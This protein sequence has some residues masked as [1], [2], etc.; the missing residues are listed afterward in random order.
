LWIERLTEHCDVAGIVVIGNENFE[1][2]FCGRTKLAL[3]CAIGVKNFHRVA[4]WEMEDAIVEGTIV[5]ILNFDPE[6]AVYTLL[7]SWS[8]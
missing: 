5:C 3:N 7:R 2:A 6:A 1:R 8:Y 4:K